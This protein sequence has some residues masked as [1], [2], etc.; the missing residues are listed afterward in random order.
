[1]SEHLINLTEDSFEQ[2]VINSDM[3]VMVDFWATWC[4][5][6]RMVAPIIEQI[7]E[8]YAGKLKVCKLDVDTAR[9][10]SVKYGIMSIPS[11]FIFKNGEV[12]ERMVGARPKQYYDEILA[13]IIA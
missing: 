3:P 5:P 4:G 9:D 6:C 12:A 8:E 10:I 2:E 7:A 1:M 13:E 11:V